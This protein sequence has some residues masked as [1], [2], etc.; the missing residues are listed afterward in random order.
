[1]LRYILWVQKLGIDDTS[2]FFIESSN[3]L[4]PYTAV[5]SHQD[6]EFIPDIFPDPVQAMFPVHLIDSEPNR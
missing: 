5:T 4:T 3:T 1:M 2:T 6:T